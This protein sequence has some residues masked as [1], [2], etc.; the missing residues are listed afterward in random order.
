[1]ASLSEHPSGELISRFTNDIS[2]LSTGLNN[3]I[4]KAVREPLR[5]LACLIAAAWISWQLLL[6]SLLIAPQTE[7]SQGTG[8][9]FD[10]LQPPDRNIRG[11]P[12]R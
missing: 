1:M 3:L 6:F 12:N 7:H 11:N 10:T 9:S 5:M 2:A 8:G 4:G